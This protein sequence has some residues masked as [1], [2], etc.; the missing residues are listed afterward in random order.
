MSELCAVINSWPLTHTSNDGDNPTPITPA[1]FL[2]GGIALAPIAGIV[3]IDGIASDERLAFV[4]NKDVQNHRTTYFRNLSMR[5]FR[6]YPLPNATNG[7]LQKSIAV[8]D[9]LLREDNVPRMKWKLARIIE[10]HRGRDGNIQVYTIQLE[11]GKPTQ[12]AAQVLYPLEVVSE[13]TVPEGAPEERSE[14]S[15]SE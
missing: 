9:V 7:Y 11:A 1:H 10:Q 8:G 2:K 5:C 6:E 13:P 3:P 12:R 14:A 4:C 15:M